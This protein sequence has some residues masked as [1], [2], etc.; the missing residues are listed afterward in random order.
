MA[1]DLDWAEVFRTIHLALGDT[2]SPLGG[3]RGSVFTYFVIRS[4]MRAEDL[5]TPVVFAAR[6][7]CAAD[8]IPYGTAVFT[9]FAFSDERTLRFV[10]FDILAPLADLCARWRF[11][12]PALRWLDPSWVICLSALISRMPARRE[13]F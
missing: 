3:T 2:C 6:P 4:T 13:W 9:R 12:M 1:F 11:F 7:F 5:E 8:L 10:R